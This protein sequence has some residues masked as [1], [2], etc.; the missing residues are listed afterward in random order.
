MNIPKEVKQVMDKLK[1]KGFESYIVGG[2]LRDILLKKEPQDWDITTSARP[3]DIQKTFKKSFYKNKFLTVTVQTSSQDPR[4]KELEEDKSSSR[5]FTDVREVEVTTFRS[6]AKY[7][8]KRHPDKIKF[9]KTLKED[10][11]RRDFTVNAMALDLPDKVIDPFSGQK[12]LKD[13]IIRTVGNPSERFSEDALRIMRAVRLA[14]ALDFRIEQKTAGAI[15]KNAPWLQAVSKERIREEFLKIIMAERAAE[16]MENLRK[17]G[18]LKY[19]VPE[20]EEGY[21]VEQNKHHIYECY[22]HGLRS[23]DYAVKKGFN[24]DVRLAAL[25]HDIGK[26]KTKRGKGEDATFYGHEI[27]GAK[28]TAQILE[29]LKFPK[30]TIEKIVKLVRYHLFYYNVDEVTDS[31]VRRLVRQVGPESMEELLQVRMADRIGSGV[32]KA[33]PYKLRH[34]KYII[35]KVSQDPISVKRLEVGGRDIMKVLGIQSG[36]KIGKILYILLGIVLS[37]PEKNKKDFLEKE[38][39]KLG[40]LPEGELD[41]LGQR[42]VRERENLEMKRDEMTKKK[43]W[44]T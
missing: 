12:D 6:E 14:A 29:R 40:K 26:P 11:A 10:L 3:E 28:M 17:L 33:E 38:I 9:A 5:P 24:K 21:G 27:V 32:P 22:E 35:E 4:L 15:K 16:G 44:V 19:I 43:Y 23:L 30:K 18:L 25:L 2:C 31:S 7:T 39:K 1:D 42:A 36:P 34:L 13:K 8:D 41:S 20:L 37:D